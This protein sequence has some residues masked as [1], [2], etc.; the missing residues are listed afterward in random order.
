LI[1]GITL[2]IG[3]AALA[4]V[5]LIG[6]ISGLVKGIVGFAMPMIIIS[7]VSSIL[8]PELALATLILPTLITNGMQAT[9]QGLFAA[10]ASVVQFKVFLIAG[11]ITLV[12]AAQFVRILPQAVMVLLIGVP[13]V[14]FAISQL[15]GKSLRLPAASRPVEIGVGTIAGFMG[16]L[17]GIWGPPTVAFLTATDTP[18]ADQMRVQG[19]I[20][21]LG[22]VALVLAHIQSGVLRAETLPLSVMM[23]I[24]AVIGMVIGGRIQDHIDQV[25]FRKV[26]LW[27]LLIV[28][29]NLVRRGLF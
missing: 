2:P 23:I 9:R 29:L 1:L 13:I 17:S 27:V 20:Y 8:S 16:G 15:A 24:P 28:G 10:L 12:I 4:L 22:S 18:K 21:G 19:V 14:L 25:M 6:V 11:F 5:L 26:T 3:P 7:G